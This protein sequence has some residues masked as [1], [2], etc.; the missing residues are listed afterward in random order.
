M[1][2]CLILFTAVVLFPS[3]G[4]ASDIP[5]VINGCDSKTHAH[6]EMSGCLQRAEENSEAELR[7]TESNLLGRISHSAE[8]LQDI[9]KIRDTFEEGRQAYRAYRDSEC[10]FYASVASGNRHVSD[11]RLACRAD[12]NSKRVAQLKRT[13]SSWK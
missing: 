9:S 13:L 7:L 3:V 6:A 10:E 4:R 8:D 5:D 11:V 12:M 1:F 2:R